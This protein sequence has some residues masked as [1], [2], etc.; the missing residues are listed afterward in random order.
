M[1]SLV[2]PSSSSQGFSRTDT[3]TWEEITTMWPLSCTSP[4]SQSKAKEWEMEG[5]FSAHLSLKLEEMLQVLCREKLRALWRYQLSNSHLPLT[6]VSLTVPKQCCHHSREDKMTS[7][8]SVRQGLDDLQ[9]FIPASAILWPLAVGLKPL[10][11]PGT[12]QQ[13]DSHCGCRG[14]LCWCPID[15]P[16]LLHSVMENIG[17]HT[18]VTLEKKKSTMVSKSWNFF[19]KSSISLLLKLW[20]SSKMKS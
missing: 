7:R 11:L 13:A 2:H 9:R 19:S 16:D 20:S 1:E 3:V 6:W 17:F 4:P 5:A 18:L 15:D 12:L 14:L 10:P 8:S